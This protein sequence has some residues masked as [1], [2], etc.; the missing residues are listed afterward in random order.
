MKISAY[1]AS[2]HISLPV[3]QSVHGIKI[4]PLYKETLMFVELIKYF[5]QN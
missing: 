1:E 5:Y 2:K 4:L 3:K